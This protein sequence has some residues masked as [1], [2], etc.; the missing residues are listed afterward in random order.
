[1]TYYRNTKLRSAEMN[2]DFFV[3]LV[4]LSE[5]LLNHSSVL[6]PIHFPLLPPLLLLLFALAPLP[7]FSF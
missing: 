3:C 7:L 6:T 1:M 2:H 5:I 4:P